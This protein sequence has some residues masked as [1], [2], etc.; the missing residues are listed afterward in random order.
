MSELS[1]RSLYR[2]Y[3]NNFIAIKDF[4]LDVRDKEMVAVVGPAECGKSVLLHII[5]GLET[6]SKGEIL[7]DGEVINEIP[8]KERGIAMVFQ[9]F[10]LYPDMTVYDN[11]A[12]GLLMKKM[13]KLRIQDEVTKIAQKLELDAIL[14]K[15]P[16][17]LKPRETLRVV[18]GRALAREPKII[19]MDDPLVR[20]DKD[21]R[22]QMLDELCMLQKKLGL[23]ILYVTEDPRVACLSSER[24]VAM[25]AGQILQI[26]TPEDLYCRPHNMKTAGIIMRPA[27]NFCEVKPEIVKDEMVMMFGNMSYEVPKGLDKIIHEGEYLGKPVIAGIHAEDIRII[28]ESENTGEYPFE[29]EVRK[30]IV[31]HGIPYACFDFAGNAFVANIEKLPQIQPEDKIAFDFDR[32]KVIFFD[33]ET[34]QAIYFS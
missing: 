23:T 10:V 32:E 33:K 29:I 21:T 9:N 18:L 28:P 6:P 4:N 8:A 30:I 26:G 13:S 27:M 12:F 22:W 2:T 15:K 34:G 25:S 14:E 24:V 11:I 1:I 5:A 7:I 31:E 3:T 19:L 16:A 20:M 17:H